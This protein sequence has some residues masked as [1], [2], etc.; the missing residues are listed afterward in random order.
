MPL[1]HIRLMPD[2]ALSAGAYSGAWSIDGQ[3]LTTSV[4]EDAAKTGDRACDAVLRYT[5]L[6]GTHAVALIERKTASRG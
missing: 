4:A 3:Q 6:S 1:F 2:G 5:W